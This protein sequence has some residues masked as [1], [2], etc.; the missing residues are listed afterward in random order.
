MLNREAVPELIQ[1][2]MNAHNLYHELNGLLNDEQRRLRMKRDLN[3]LKNLCG[4]S[5][6]S[7]RI[8]QKMTELLR[9]ETA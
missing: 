9:N 1:H 6:A 2:K 8:A 5:G 7:A 4:K 3:E